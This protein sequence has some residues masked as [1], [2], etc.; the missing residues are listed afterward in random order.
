MSKMGSHDPFGSLKHK[1][2]PK[3]KLSFD[4]RPLKVGNHPEFL[5][6]RW[7]ASYHWRALNK[8][9]NFG[10][11]LTSIEGLHIKLWTSKV[12][13]ISRLALGNSG[14]KWHFGA[15]LVARH[16]VYYK[17]E[18]GGFSQVW[19]VVSFVNPCLPIGHPCNKRAPTLH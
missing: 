3:V 4:F 6:C 17:G 11:N 5:A 2:W 19:V 9:Y 14:T 13:G 7:H 10:W 8:G 12:T 15:S 16:I 18:G 1:L